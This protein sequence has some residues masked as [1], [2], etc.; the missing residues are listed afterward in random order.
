MHLVGPLVVLFCNSGS[1]SVATASLINITIYHAQQLHTA[2]QLSCTHP[3]A[4]QAMDMAYG[5][6]SGPTSYKNAQVFDWPVQRC[7]VIHKQRIPCA[8]SNCC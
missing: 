7:L 8:A 6:D 2:M 3:A 1:A 4:K 5:Y